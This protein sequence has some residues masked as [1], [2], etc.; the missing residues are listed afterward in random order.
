MK[1]IYQF[2]SYAFF[3]FFKVFKN[4]FLSVEIDIFYNEVK[5]KSLSCIWLFATP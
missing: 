4:F 3:F 1:L 5:W 2:P